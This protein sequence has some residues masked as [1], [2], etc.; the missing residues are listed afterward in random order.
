MSTPSG[1]PV[2]ARIAPIAFGPPRIE[3]GRAPFPLTPLVGRDRELAAIL[4]LL[5]DP[6][7]RLLSLI[8]PGGVGKTRL[9]LAVVGALG[10]HFADGAVF[11]P[12]AAVADPALVLPTVAHALGVQAAGRRPAPEIV[13][14]ALQDRHLL[15]VLDNVEQVVSA[16]PDLSALLAACPGVKAL[17]TTRAALR[18][19]GE[20]QV[21]VPPLSL[22]ERGGGQLGVAMASLDTLRES[23]AVALFAQRARQVNPDFALTETNAAA[24]AEIVRRLDGL[25]LAIELAAAWTRMFPPAA[26]LGRLERR[27]PLP[28]GRTRDHP[29]R[30]RTMRDSVA[31]SDALL[32]PEQQTL[33]RRL[34]VFV[35][36][37]D[38]EAAEAVV[39]GGRAAGGGGVGDATSGFVAA[40]SVL[41]G[42]AELADKSLLAAAAGPAGEP[43]FGLLDTVR[44]YALERL[45]GGDEEA[46]TRDRH[47]AYM[48]R[49]VAHARRQMEGPD[50]TAAR[51]RVERE[52]DNARAALA[53]AHER[54]DAETVQRLAA[55]LARFWV[56][57]GYI[58]EG[59]GW[60]ER[61]VRMDAVSSPPA[62]VD[63]LHWAASFAV[64]QDDPDRA[65]ALNREAMALARASDYRLGVAMAVF[66][67]GHIAER[68]GAVDEAS[69]FYE[70]ALDL[71]RGLGE[72]VWTGVALRNLGVTAAAR[73]ALDVA[74]ARHREALAIWRDLAHPWGVPAA[75]RD[76]A[77]AALRG[78][79]VAAALPL[80]LESLAGWRRLREPF[81][82]ER[83]VWGLARVAQAL[84]RPERAA[85][86]LGAA[87]AL[88][89]AVGYVPSTAMR[90]HY[91]DVAA[92][93]R[94]TL[95]DAPFETAWSGGRTLALDAV[96]DEAL[97]GSALPTPKSGSGGVKPDPAK[98]L[99][100]RELDVLR[101]VAAGR[102]DAEI[103]DTLFIGRRTVGSH[104]ASIFAKLGVNSRAAAVALAVRG[105]LL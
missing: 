83:C 64:G 84:G 90:T 60:L 50:R 54:G 58:T 46:E 91:D 74:A 72:T 62:R 34:A 82:L 2:A 4:D 77:D 22:P 14:T 71:F 21:P 11:V 12:L 39:G 40:P 24:I 95:G 19:R 32:D 81:H 49:L 13:A 30:H 56:I 70:E 29:Q 99:S 85:R 86:L 63:A 20:Q 51:D 89:E 79:D 41:D 6:E 43:R 88:C 103:A 66:E 5:A 96:L 102:H 37:F 33:L 45:R 31:W 1:T 78:G 35:G 100:A 92:T 67:S 73:G 15:L 93:L 97:A 7:T 105:D 52:R 23:G 9:A 53:W 59:R 16:A 28:A 27:L 87:V 69:A 55:E 36:G 17:V 18:V 3:G 101:L 8:G 98:P 10:D 94:S 68:R 104:L 80:Y 61:A 26:L 44:E 25:P 65:S 76:L 47:A 75:L 42:L 57:L 48:L 38:L